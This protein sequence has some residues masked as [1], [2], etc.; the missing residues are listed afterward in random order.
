MDSDDE[1]DF[2]DEYQKE[3]NYFDR[4]FKHVY[5]GY[6]DGIDLNALDN[7]ANWQFHRTSAK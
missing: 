5:V 1:S 7:T 3:C 4:S 6:S 2:E